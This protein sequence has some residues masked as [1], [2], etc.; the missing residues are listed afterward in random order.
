[1]TCICQCDD[2]FFTVELCTREQF[3][4]PAMPITHT[5]SSPSHPDASKPA[6]MG[7]GLMVMD[8][9]MAW[10]PKRLS[11]PGPR[12]PVS[13]YLPGIPYPCQTLATIPKH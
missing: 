6:I 10:V 8:M 13:V 1:M 5:L 9:D 3:Y 4:T 12:I 11:V 7:M 2:F